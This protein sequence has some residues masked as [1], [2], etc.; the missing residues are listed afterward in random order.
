MQH[1][2][3]NTRGT[4]ISMNQKQK[5]KRLKQ[6]NWLRKSQRH[7]PTRKRYAEAKMRELLTG[8]KTRPT[9]ADLRKISDILERNDSQ[10]HRQLKE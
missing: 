9:Y 1:Y 4:A 8:V 10:Y 2:H 3:I 6:L 5:K 7:G